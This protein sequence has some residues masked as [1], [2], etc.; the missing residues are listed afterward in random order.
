MKS[1]NKDRERTL[2]VNV[3]TSCWVGS[4]WAHDICCRERNPCPFRKWRKCP[5]AWRHGDGRATR[6]SRLP[7]AGPRGKGEAS[8]FL[9]SLRGGESWGEWSG[10]SRSTIAPN[11]RVPRGSARRRRVVPWVRTIEDNVALRRNTSR[12]SCFLH[13][14]CSRIFPFNLKF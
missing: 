7:C 12:H 6:S 8:S 9:R 5:R 13:L 2:G 3:G 11:G 4:G 14:I 10:A 1:G